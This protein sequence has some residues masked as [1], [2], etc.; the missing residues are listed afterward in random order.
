[1][2]AHVESVRGVI[3]V[4]TLLLKQGLSLRE[5]DFLSNFGA[6]CVFF[7]LKKKVCW[8]LYRQTLVLIG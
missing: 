2:Y 4:V 8:I 6:V 1:M 3:A 5:K 7:L